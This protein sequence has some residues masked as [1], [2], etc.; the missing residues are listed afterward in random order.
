MCFSLV[1]SDTAHKLCVSDFAASW[2][3]AATN[4]KDRVSSS[5]HVCSHTLYEAA[6]VVNEAVGPYVLVCPLYEVAVFQ[7]VSVH[8]VDDIFGRAQG[9]IGNRSDR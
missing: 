2:N 5:G 1:G 6:E 4:K 8:L 9:V 7:G 3:V